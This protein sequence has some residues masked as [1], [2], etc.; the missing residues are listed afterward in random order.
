[1]N[2]N[3]KVIMNKGTIL[4]QWHCMKG[5]EKLL[6]TAENEKRFVS[7][8]ET[9]PGRKINQMNSLHLMN[10]FINKPLLMMSCTA[11]LPVFQL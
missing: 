10:L 1:M 5:M 6:I 11:S 2:Y 4:P 9:A 8:E 7:V 3:E